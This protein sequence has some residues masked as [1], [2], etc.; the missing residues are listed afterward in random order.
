MRKLFTLSILALT[1]VLAHAQLSGSGYYRVKNYGS[2]NY[3]WVCDN[4]GSVN[5][6]STSAD[7]GA[8]QLW[9]ELDRSLSEPASVLYFDSKGD[10]RWD[11]R[12]QT[13]GVYDIINHYVDIKTLG[14]TGGVTYYQLS[15]TQGMTVY[16][17]DAGK[18]SSRVEYT[19]LGT[20]G[21]GAYRRWIVEPID[22][23]SDNYFGIK[24]TITA[25]GK[26]Y[27]PFYADFPFSFASTG[28]KAYYISKI[29][30]NI[31][32]LKQVTTT[33][34]PASTPLLIE[35][36]SA[37]KS[38]NRLNLL[39]GNYTRPSDNLLR[40]VY[41]C[42][43]F[44]NTS[45]DA[46]TAFNA[47]TMRVWNVD[48]D[49]C[50]TLSTA[51]DGLHA[52]F[53]TNDNTPYLNANQSY[54]AVSANTPAQLVVMTEEEYAQ[55]EIL[56]TTLTISMATLTLRPADTATLTVAVAPSDATNKALVWSTSDASVATVAD[57]AVRAVAPGTAIITVKAADGSGI[58]ATCQVTVL[59][60]F[61]KEDVNH[62]GQTD[63]QD[64]LSIY[65]YMQSAD[66]T[67]DRTLLDINADG[68]VDTQDVLLIYD[69][70]QGD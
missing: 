4:T 69:M 28:M 53:F 61:D 45:R 43:E 67:V 29:D 6:N 51:T 26:Y 16:L 31:A 40:G 44:R 21:T 14:T 33:V 25:G 23:N 9:P 30:G 18:W 10:N 64:V 3:V 5:Y 32:V 17:T 11:I 22:A 70:I 63:T 8:M 34:I 1:S 27:A 42:N 2:G 52:S 58:S 35:C 50:L 24:P 46:I 47:E 66:P 20:T 38:N 13:T 19:S 60:P 59:K 37:D 12:S 49:G 41:F 48:S 55:R 62:D 54:L 68:Q 57:G 36:S 15:A 7:M 39:T 56:V 65:D